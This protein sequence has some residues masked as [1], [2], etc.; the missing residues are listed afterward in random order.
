MSSTTCTP[1]SPTITSREFLTRLEAVSATVEQL[2]PDQPIPV[3]QLHHRQ[4]QIARGG[5]SLAAWDLYAHSIRLEAAKEVAIHEGLPGLA[6]TVERAIRLLDD[7]VSLYA[8]AG[9][10]E[11][12][13]DAHIAAATQREHR[14]CGWPLLREY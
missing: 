13:T 5:E 7:A 10:D 1:T 2:H 3:A 12:D 11:A 6:V 8:F 9:R 4:A 14:G